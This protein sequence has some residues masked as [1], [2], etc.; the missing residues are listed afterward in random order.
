M[1][2]KLLM[3]AAI[4][5]LAITSPVAAQDYEWSARAF[6]G[7]LL[8]GDVNTDLDEVY[9]YDLDDYDYDDGFDFQTGFVIGGAIGVKKSDFILEDVRFEVE[10][11]YRDQDVE[12]NYFDFGDDIL[13]D[14]NTFSAPSQAIA[15]ADDIDF[16]ADIAEINVEVISIL[17]NAWYDY[18]LSEK[19]TIY[20]GGGLGIGF[21][22]ISTVDAF[23]DDEFDGSSSGFAW[24]IGAGANYDVSEK[25]AVGVGYRFYRS[26]FSEDGPS[27]IIS[28]NALLAETIFKF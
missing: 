26:R 1:R 22:D 12:I 25:I 7:V 20:G 6:G 28:N 16:D 27:L 21:V 10:A 24:Q 2:I 5:A 4:G 8:G 13:L 17:A 23:D 14:S 15:I 11:A 9:G 19:F 3:A 18:D